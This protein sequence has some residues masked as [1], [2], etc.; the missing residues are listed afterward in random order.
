MSKQPVIDNTRPGQF[1]WLL[2]QGLFY[3]L[4]LLVL[5]P[6]TVGLAFFLKQKP[7]S[8]RVR[9]LFLTIAGSWLLFTPILLPTWRQ[10]W[11]YT[12]PLSPLVSF[13]LQA[14]NDI[15]L[16][17]KPKSLQEHLVAEEQALQAQEQ[18][19]SERASHLP[20]PGVEAGQLRLGARIQ[21]DSFS[22]HVGFCQREGYLCMEE[23]I[24]DQHLFL[25][26]TTGAGKSETIK[27]LVTEILTAT[28]RH[29]YFVDGKGDE[30]LAND[31]RALAHQFGRGMAP[32][33]K[34]GFDQYGAVYDGFRGSAADVY[35]RL[36]ALI[37]V[38][39]VE[40][41][42][43]YYA[44]GNRDLLQLICYPRGGPPRTFEA[45]RSRLQKAWLQQAY[46]DNPVELE[47]IDS[48]S[49]KEIEGLARR[50]RPLVREFSPCIG[51]EGFALE[52]TPC[53]IFSLRVQSV[54]DT[55]KRFLDF[56]VE[57]LKDFIGKRQQH[58]SVLIID[59]FGQFSNKNITALL[60]LAR[61]SQLGIILA[62]Q[63]VASLK[64]ETTKKLVLANTRTKLL[65]ATDFP[66]DVATLAGTFYQIEA[67]IQ[68]QDGGMTGLGSARVQHAFKVDMN[69]V[70]QLQPG[71][72]FLIRQRQA[73]K[74]RIKAIGK[75]EHIAAQP[76]ELRQNSLTKEAKKAK[77]PPKLPPT[78]RDFTPGK[79]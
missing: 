65:M 67:S 5:G 38:Q 18:R 44:D 46:H 27:R 60:S 13:L 73:A 54:G 62:T 43:Q 77:T 7:V 49:Y 12:I 26:G 29:I 59:E 28:D 35:N 53:A 8:R 52:E 50:I 3:G 45:V 40:G 15:V 36:C 22:T 21:G 78:K 24:L 51:P 48:L 79:P 61:S 16:R 31:M 70:A 64:D 57:D 19:L 33:F 6:L 71:E 74:I 39:E 14:F 34:L 32:V 58:P 47:M 72:A 75:V 41:N 25:L 20:L 1:E 11:F 69:E 4:L 2:L 56:L 42:A 30:D 37:S 10:V 23:G 17:L 66:E 76:A 9:L 63:D 55:S 68:Q